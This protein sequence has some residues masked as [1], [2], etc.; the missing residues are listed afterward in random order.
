MDNRLQGEV[1]G[2]TSFKLY[3]DSI[4]VDNSQKQKCRVLNYGSTVDSP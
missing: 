2:G 4:F 1:F 3:D